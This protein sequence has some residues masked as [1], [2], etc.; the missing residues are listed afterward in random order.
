MEYWSVDKI[1]HP[2]FND[3]ETYF[4]LDKNSQFLIILISYYL[5]AYNVTQ[6]GQAGIED[7]WYRCVQSYLLKLIAFLNIKSGYGI[8][9]VQI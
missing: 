5:S 6:P 1:R 7:W 9:H 8:N 4:Q 2:S 3:R